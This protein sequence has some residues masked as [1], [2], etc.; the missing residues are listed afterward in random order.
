MYL[1]MLEELL[2]GMDV[3]INTT[4][5]GTSTLIPVGSLT[6]AAVAAAN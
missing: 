2:P 6:G 5:G 3:Y 1:E 4:D